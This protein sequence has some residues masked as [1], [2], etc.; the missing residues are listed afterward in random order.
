MAAKMQKDIDLNQKSTVFLTSRVHPG[1]SNSSFMIQGAIEFLLQP[2]NPQ[3]KMLRETFIFK[4][5]PIL[6]PDGVVNGYYRCN[7]V[8][9]D[10][11]RR[12]INPSKLL[13]PTIYYTKKLIKMCHQDNQ[14]L[15]FCDFHG[16]TRKRNVFMYGCVSAQ[17]E[18]NQHK[19]NNLI[20]IMPYLL[21]QKNKYFNFADC[22]FANE[23]EKESTGRMVMF[24]EFG[25]LNSYTLESTFYSCLNPRRGYKKKVG[26]EDDQQITAEQ[27]VT[28]GEDFCKTL[29]VIIN[30]KI[31]KRKFM[32]DNSFPIGAGG[33]PMSQFLLNQ[34]NNDS[35]DK[36]K[37]Y[38]I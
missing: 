22:K 24:K 13:H 1:E 21:D 9:A 3:A 11:N 10:L 4:I 18:L 32:S 8:G 12:W 25:I 17:T 23:K 16:H 28:V 2:N 7:S 33:N 27:L 14:V 6:N 34:S 5:I 19:N 37:A 30:S 36:S 29:I 35:A 15:L 26:V 38:S 20:R 31:L